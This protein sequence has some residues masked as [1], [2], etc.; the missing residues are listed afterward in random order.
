MEYKLQQRNL[1]L[2]N[3]IITL[4]EWGR[5]LTW[6]NLENNILPTYHKVKDKR[7]IC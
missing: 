1:L 4:K 3:N 7:T 5:E 2:M 6:V